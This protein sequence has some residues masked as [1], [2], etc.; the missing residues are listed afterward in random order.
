MRKRPRESSPIPATSPSSD[1]DEGSP[2][3]LAA[4]ERICTSNLQYVT[5]GMPVRLNGETAPVAAAPN[6]ETESPP[7]AADAEG[8]SR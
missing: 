2:A 8:E 5:D 4:G 3:G 7:V 6:A 1:I